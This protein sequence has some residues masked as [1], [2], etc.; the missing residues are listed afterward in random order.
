MR[1]TIGGNIYRLRFRHV[2]TQ[3]APD[4]TKMSGG[5]MRLHPVSMQ[6]GNVKA[7]KALGTTRCL[8][9]MLEEAPI[10]RWVQVAVGDAVCSASEPRGYQKEVGRQYA[11][12]RA[13]AHLPRPMARQLFGVYMQ[14]GH[15]QLVDLDVKA[16]DGT[17]VPTTLRDLVSRETTES[18]DPA[19]VH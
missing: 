5:P 16:A 4:G 14:T 7:R 12:A 6:A 17:H 11:L 2:V 19:L 15:R 18:S 9:E 3:R 1:T 10:Q 13:I 8:I